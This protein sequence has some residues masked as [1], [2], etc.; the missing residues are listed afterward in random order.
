MRNLQQT[1][2][3]TY[4]EQIKLEIVPDLFTEHQFNLIKKKLKNQQLSNSEKNEFSRA[5][6][7]R[8][9]AIYTLMNCPFENIFIYGKE[10]MLPQR[11]NEAKLLLKRYQ[12]IFRNKHILITGSFL[13]SKKY[14][15][16]DIFVITDHEKEDYNEGKVH[17]NHFT[18]EVYH[19]LFFESV[20]RLCISNKEIFPER[21]EENVSAETFISLYQELFN[22]IDQHPQGLKQTLREY[23]LQSVHLSYAP[24]PDSQELKQQSDKILEQEDKNRKELIKNIFFQT[25]IIHNRKKISK[26]LPSISKSYQD[27][28]KYYPQ[29]QEHYQT[30]INTFQKV[31]D[32][33]G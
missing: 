30:M 24:I 6:S 25:L 18:K 28:I 5:I 31:I 21:V 26:I 7:K 19:S 3:L 9:K 15:D 22:D 11:L 4:L 1:L 2:N 29:H 32:F 14:K 12:R 23:L 13:Y 17:I 33:A 27:L 20:R 8:I 10:K 16:I